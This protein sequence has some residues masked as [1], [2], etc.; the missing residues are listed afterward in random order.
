MSEILTFEAFE[1]ELKLAAQERQSNWHRLQRIYRAAVLRVIE[2][3]DTSWIERAWQLV[4][5]LPEATRFKNA[6]IA[7]CGG[8]AGRDEQGRFILAASKPLSYTAKTGWLYQPSRNQHAQ[9]LRLW[10]ETLQAIAW[11]AIKFAPKPK[12]TMSETEAR[13]MLAKLAKYFP[14]TLDKNAHRHVQSA[15]ELVN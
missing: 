4:Q 5:T 11:D 7:A 1:A 15:L 3:K 9:A 6:I 13:K 2:S 8:I 14:A 10:R 12:E